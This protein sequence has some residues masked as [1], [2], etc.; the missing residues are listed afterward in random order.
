MTVREEVHAQ[1]TGPGGPFELIEEDVLGQRMPVFK[2]REH[3]LREL[4]Q[5]SALH[6]DKPYMVLGDRVISYADHV[7]KVASIAAALHEE[8]GIGPGDRVALIA[9]NRPEWVMAF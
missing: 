8:H 3:S 9:A 2:T 7:E 1:L 5:N 6:G 4:L